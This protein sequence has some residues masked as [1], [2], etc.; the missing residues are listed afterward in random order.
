MPKQITSRPRRHRSDIDGNRHCGALGFPRDGLSHGGGH[1]DRLRMRPGAAPAW[2]RV[3]SCDEP[4]PRTYARHEVVIRPR[5]PSWPTNLLGCA[6]CFWIGPWPSWRSWRSRR[7]RSQPMR[8]PR[9][10]PCRFPWGIDPVAEAAAGPHQDDPGQFARRHGPFG[11]ARLPQGVSDQS[12]R[13][14]G[15]R[16]SSGA[17]HQRVCLLADDGRRPARLVGILL[18]RD[19]PV[20]IA[21]GV[22]RE[23]GTFLG[24]SRDVA[25]FRRSTGF[26]IRELLCTP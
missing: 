22:E 6:T 18:D 20:P 13:P 7:R 11:A 15:I 14:N 2:R 17:S 23:F 21:M 12:C 9:R 8:S 3:S 16:A 19:R 26:C 25:V 5:R 10:S 1:G 4:M 24:L